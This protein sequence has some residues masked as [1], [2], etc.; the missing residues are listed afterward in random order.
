MH[1]DNVCCTVQGAM[2]SWHNDSWQPCIYYAL[3]NRIPSCDNG[4]SWVHHCAPPWMLCTEKHAVSVTNWI[5]LNLCMQCH[6]TSTTKHECCIT[7]QGDWLKGCQNQTCKTT[8]IFKQ[9]LHSRNKSSSEITV[10]STTSSV[11]LSMLKCHFL[12]EAIRYYS[13]FLY[14]CL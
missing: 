3:Q 9:H 13:R 8:I 12:A 2:V 10:L 5:F 7:R 1:L 4:W 6:D 11:S 14:I